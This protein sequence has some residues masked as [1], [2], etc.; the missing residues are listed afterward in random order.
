ALGALRTAASLPDARA[1]AERAMLPLL[2]ELGQLAE[3][4]IRCERLLEEH[5][6]PALRE[7]LQRIQAA[8]GVE[9]R[10]PAA[11]P[12]EAAV[13]GDEVAPDDWARQFDWGD[14]HVKL[15]NVVGLEAVKRQIELRILAP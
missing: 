1:A 11:R 10:E 2:R 5:D 13:A 6:D 3:A 12:A 7:E 15:A 14:L 9:E 4:L 8:R